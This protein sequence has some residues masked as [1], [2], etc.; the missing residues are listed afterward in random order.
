M[1]YFAFRH[2]IK[3]IAQRNLANVKNVTC[4]DD[5]KD[6]PDS[7][8]VAPIDD[9]DWFSPDMGLVL[10]EALTPGTD[11]YYWTSHFVEVPIDFNHKMG[12]IRRKVIPGTP[13]KWIC[14]TNNYALVKSPESRELCRYHTRASMWFERHPERVCRL[15]RDLS[16]MNRTLASRTSLGFTKPSIS[17]A[18]LVRKYRKYRA[19][20]TN[21]VPAELSWSGTYMGLMAELMDD[22]KLR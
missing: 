6:V 7:S 16:V 14:T 9:D 8:L 13:R 2:R 18:F 5:W 11:G 4:V 1:P 17:R 21:P 10:E 20:Y 12:L 3:Q 15:E 19:L 22:L